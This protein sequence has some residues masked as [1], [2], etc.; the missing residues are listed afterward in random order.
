[1]GMPDVD[2]AQAR[3]GVPSPRLPSLTR[4]VS[5]EGD[6]RVLDLIGRA[7]R[8]DVAAFEQLVEPQLPQLYRLATA[9]VGPEEA[10]DVT[11]ETLVSAWRELGKLQRADRLGAWLRSILLNRARNVLRTRKRHPAVAFDPQFGHGAGLFEEPISGLH[12]RW[13]VEDALA[14]LRPDERAVIV[15]HYLADLTLRQV[16]ET[17]SIREGTAKSRLHAGLRVLRR[18]FAEEPA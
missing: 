5:H 7:R 6:S 1:M 9:M 13:A 4:V 3:H 2:P 15:L 12:G 16:A 17:L 14:L 18:H 10:R 11:Q 8:G